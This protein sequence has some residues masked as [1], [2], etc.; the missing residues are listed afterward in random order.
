MES[1]SATS[2]EN[3]KSAILGKL[4][5]TVLKELK[6]VSL[7]LALLYLLFTISHYIFLRGQLQ[8]IMTLT[9]AVTVFLLIIINLALHKFDIPIRSAHPI[10]LLIA[11]IVLF[12]GI[13]HLYLADDPLHTTNLALIV[14]G[15]GFLF[16][17]TITYLIIV[18]MTGIS[19]LFVAIGS[20]NQGSWFHFGFFLISSIALSTII[21]VVRKRTRIEAEKTRIS[22]N[23]QNEK[24]KQLI[25]E[26]QESQS[27]YKDLFDNANDLIQSV[28][29]DGKFEY[30]NRAWEELLGYTAAD[31]KN[32][33]LIDIIREDNRKKC[34]EIFERVSRGESFKNQETV[35]VAKS[36][37]E[38]FVEGSISPQMK[39]DQFVASRAI[40]RDITTRKAAEEELKRLHTELKNVNERLKEA[41]ADIKSE[42][43]ILSK[44]I[45]DE[46]IG[47]ITD[48]A[49]IITAVTDKA[50]QLTGKS[51]LE[52]LN[53]PLTEMFEDASR[54]SITEA[55]RLG[56]IKNF[57]SVDAVLK[58]EK[59]TDFGY[60]VNIM[61]LNS[62]KEKQLLVILRIDTEL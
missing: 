5:A 24:S 35:F 17:S 61:R 45:Q 46:E 51:R 9:A 52:I 19:W 12:N 18:F 62:L 47:F 4:N 53:K 29:P 14:L 15:S 42:K 31:R 8:L 3:D 43:D 25:A 26:L 56:N 16:L 41:Y 44:A 49:G 40:F 27:K 59:P 34:K 39:A 33:T 57:H 36:S 38:I 54:A 30:V 7:G 60:I 50:T 28:K 21:H 13:L 11:L 10:G 22:E 58:T 23:Y 2:S 20:T 37:R 6:P 55:I 48:S 1:R 32:L